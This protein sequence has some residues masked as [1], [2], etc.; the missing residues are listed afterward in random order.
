MIQCL[1]L[2]L[3]SRSLP[4]ASGPRSAV[5]ARKPLSP[6]GLR[7]H[8]SYPETACPAAGP[9]FEPQVSAAST[10]LKRELRKRP[11]PKAREGDLFV[12]ASNYALS[13]ESYEAPLCYCAP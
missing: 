10:Q 6:V 5:S 12:R 4:S 11:Y 7:G 9:C 2:G 3:I 1:C 13:H 8:L